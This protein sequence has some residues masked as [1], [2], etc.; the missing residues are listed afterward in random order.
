MEFIAE[1]LLCG[2]QFQISAAACVLGEDRCARKAEYMVF[3]E[4]L[5]YGV[6]HLAKVASVALVKDN[7]HSLLED[8]MVLVLL[9]EDGEF[10][11]GGDDDTVV[12]VAAVLILVFQLPL[13]DGGGGVAVRCALLKSV[14]LLHSL[15]VKVFSI[16]DE[17]HLVYV[18][19]A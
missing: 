17:Q 9:N 14:I 15:V 6:V 12:A 4:V 1:C 7:H 2:F 13:K 3:L 10:L 19:K 8:G 18:V 16:H 5:G 11:Y